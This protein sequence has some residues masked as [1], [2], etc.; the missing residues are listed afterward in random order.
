MRATHP[1][2]RPGDA[3]AAERARLANA[4]WHVLGDPVRRAAY[5]Q[6][7]QGHCVARRPEY[8][9]TAE[10]PGSRAE[11]SERF[12]RAFHLATLRAGAAI[13]ALGLVLLLT[14]GSG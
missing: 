11:S 5:N 10:W 13:V 8:P 1:D 14:L 7:L 2:R 4:A 6:A 9:V 12:R 3:V